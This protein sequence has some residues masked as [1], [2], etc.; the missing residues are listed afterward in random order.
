LITSESIASSAMRGVQLL[1]R[2]G[3]SM[4]VRP[5]KDGW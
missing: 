5:V 4:R 3:V 2:E 1:L